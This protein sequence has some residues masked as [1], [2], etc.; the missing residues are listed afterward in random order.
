MLGLSGPAQ[1]ATPAKTP[2]CECRGVSNDGVVTTGQDPAPMSF[3]VQNCKD[4]NIVFT[5]VKQSQ[6]R[7]V[8]TVVASEDAQLGPTGFKLV[9]ADGTEIESP[10]SVRLKIENSVTN[11][12]RY[13]L[14]QEI[15]KTSAKASK[16]VAVLQNDVKTTVS[17]LQ[18]KIDQVATLAA[19]KAS[20]EEVKSF[21]EERLRPIQKELDKL[22]GGLKIFA[23]LS[24]TTAEVTQDLTR[25]QAILAGTKVKKKFLGSEKLDKD[26]EDKASANEVKMRD[27]AEVIRRAFGKQ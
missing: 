7:I 18:N 25:G 21:L 5:I 22:G 4:V 9:L 12:V 26:V 3:S 27:A 11:Q 20:M 13:D 17:S 2:T 1:A 24:T 19:N 14:Q 15:A 10:D 6:T 16:E 8:T 23:E